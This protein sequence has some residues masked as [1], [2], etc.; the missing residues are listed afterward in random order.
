MALQ[1]SFLLLQNKTLSHG[2][3]DHGFSYAVMLMYQQRDWLPT[4]TEMVF[5]SLCKR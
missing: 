5:Y 3:N 4:G 2:F 1:P